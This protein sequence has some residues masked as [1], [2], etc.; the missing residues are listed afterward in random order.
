MSAETLTADVAVIGGGVAGMTAAARA[1]AGGKKVIVLEAKE[2]ELYI[3]SSRLTGGVF[4][5]ALT[6]IQTDPDQIER[7]IVD[8]CAPSNSKLA[9]VIAED[10]IRAVRFLQSQGVRF[11]RG[12]PDPWHAFVVA[13]PSLGLMGDGWKGRGGDVLLRTLE[14]R[15]KERGSMVRRGSRARRLIIEDGAVA[16]V[17]GEGFVVRAPAVVIADGGF[18]SNPDMIR[19]PITPEP[20]KVIQRN[21]VSGFGDGLLMALE[22][23]AAQ[24]ADMTGFYGHIVSRDAL[25]REEIKLYP[26]LDELARVALVVTPDGRRFCDEGLGGTYI[27]NKMA[28]LPDPASTTVV[29]DEAAWEGPGRNRFLSPN[30]TLDKVGATVHRAN[31]LEELARMAGLDVAGFLETVE[32]YNA[33]C[34]SGD[35]SGLSPARTTAKFKPLPIR[36]APFAAAPAAS[37]ITHTFGGI[38]VD[39]HARALRPDGTPIPGLYAVG[40]SCG[41]VD[42]GPKIGYV[43]GMS[44]GGA[45][46]LRAAEHITG[47]A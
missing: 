21:G 15:L 33:A 36:R 2:E 13:P 44:K 20:D 37:G 34:D 42:G 29:W 6:D 8:A 1:S 41:G 46:G 11:L 9:R 17:E 45:T 28:A 14:D 27:A 35:F 16:G 38:E 4:H 39:E 32:H 25:Q 47:G 3:C 5:A 18:Q 23:G 22:A 43:G 40:A 30:P 19:G 12:S 10:T 7:I 31:S 24:T 26:W